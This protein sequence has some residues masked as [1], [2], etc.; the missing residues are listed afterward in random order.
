MVSCTTLGIAQPCLQLITGLA[1]VFIQEWSDVQDLTAS[2]TKVL[3]WEVE[4][5]QEDYYCYEQEFIHYFDVI[6]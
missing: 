1:G 5:E 6:F 2:D 4:K 3:S